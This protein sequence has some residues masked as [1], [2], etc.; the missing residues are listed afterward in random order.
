MSNYDQAADKAKKQLDKISPTMCYA[1]WS[2]VSMH[3]HNGMTHSCYHPP[4]HKVDLQ[5][6]KQNP[7]ALHNTKEKKEQRR[8]M[9]A[10]ERPQGCSYCWR[11]EDVGGRS[12]RVYRSGE[13]WAQN[14]REEIAEAGADGNINPRYVEVNFNQACNLKCSYCSPHLSN[15]WEKEIK[16]FGPYNIVQ[17]EHNNLNSLGKTGLMPLKISQAD[18]PYVTAFWK[19]WPE[20]Y[21]N[22]EVF[23]MTGGEPLMDSNT[24][25]VLDY[26][27]KNPNAWLEISVTSNMCPPKPKLMDMFIESLQRLEE[28]QIWEDPEKFNPNSGNNWYVAPACKNFAT[29]VSCDGFGEQAEYMRNG[30]NFK[31]LQNNVNRILEETDNSTITFINTFN[32]LSLTSLQEYLQWILELRD[33]YAKDRQGI[34][35]IPIPDNGGHKH[36]DYEVRP[37]QRIWFD[38][39]LLR[40][41]LWQCIQIMPDYYQS[42]L[43]EAIAFMELNRADEVNIDYRGFKDFEID[44]VRRNLEWMK[45]GS[46]MDKEELLKARAN[47]FK[48]FSQHDERRKTNFLQVF[49]EMEDWWNICKEAEALI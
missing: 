35:Y 36:P 48:F 49:P 12:D 21:K 3:L 34:K 22:L 37:K 46:I 40:A 33:K 30:M 42:Y 27:Y 19:W 20:M 18:N 41:P 38:I 32:L 29:F 1:K 43:E 14:A 6:L 17:G 47:F 11:I 39:P 25:K 24:F 5:E 4:T 16:Q 10:G 28:I 23:R 45:A 15:T 26:V 31:M 13:Y 7:T 44:K 9:L 2:Q 8:Q